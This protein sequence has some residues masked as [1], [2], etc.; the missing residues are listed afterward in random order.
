[1]KTKAA[2]F[3]NR[4]TTID[5]VF[6]NSHKERLAQITEL[7]PVVIA[8]KHFETHAQD[9]AELEV[10]FSTWGMPVLNA[11][12]L[13][14]LPSLKALF[15]AAGSVKFFAEPFLKQRVLVIS[16]WVANAIPVAEFTVSQIL[17]ANKGYF[18]NIRD[19]ASPDGYKTA[20]VGLVNYSS[21]VALLGAGMVGRKVIELLAPFQLEVLVFDPFLAEEKA[22]NLGVKKVS[23]METFQNSRV[24][25][26]HLADVPETKGLLHTPHF[27]AMPENEV[28]INTGRGS[29]VVETE[30]ITV[31]EQRPDLTALLDV[32]DPEPPHSNSG[33]YHLLNAILSSHIAGSIGEEVSRMAY[34]IIEEFLAWKEDRLLRYAV[35]LE[36]LG[37]MA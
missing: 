20:F 15:Y 17:L 21:T 22:I 7:Y 28:F 32:T 8:S 11:E 13:A 14:K 34:T 25:S 16:G 27:Q 18:R 26:N 6:S 37:K 2:F 36:I 23:L 30:P 24:I 3:S 35:T 5:Q 31:L 29:T 12:Q 9:L 33:L 10:I 19:C 1:L 4:E